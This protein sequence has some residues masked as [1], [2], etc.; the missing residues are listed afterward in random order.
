MR[1]AAIV[2]L[3]CTAGPAMLLGNGSEA[4]PAAVHR[5]RRFLRG[6]EISVYNYSPVNQLS[7]K[8]DYGAYQGTIASG[9]MQDFYG[10]NTVWSSTISSL[11]VW[12]S[13][14]PTP[15]SPSG[16]AGMTCQIHGENRSGK[17]NSE[18]WIDCYLNGNKVAWISNNKFS[19]GDCK[20]LW[21]GSRNRIGTLCRQDNVGGDWIHYA[22]WA[23]CDGCKSKNN[24]AGPVTAS[25]GIIA[26]DSSSAALL[27]SSDSSQMPLAPEVPRP[28]GLELPETSLLS[29]AD[30]ADAAPLMDMAGA[31]TAADEISLL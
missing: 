22:F 17:T 11:N 5:E 19:Q 26:D 18:A 12:L 24:N 10:A 23:V 20:D 31:N 28:E 30:A 29:S 8:T 14:F 21:W 9:Q 25:A 3:A 4:A 2:A 13:N 6:M 16:D 7:F 15:D 27:S 1:T